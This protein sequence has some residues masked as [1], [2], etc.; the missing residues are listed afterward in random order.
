MS[1]KEAINVESAWDKVVTKYR[2]V[3]VLRREARVTESERVLKDELP[4]VIA[5]WAAANP[6]PITAKKAELEAM[7]AVE[8]K[9][10]DEALTLRRI[11]TAQ[12]NEQMLPLLHARVAEEVKNHF[13][14]QARGLPLTV[15]TDTKGGARAIVSMTPESFTVPITADPISLPLPTAMAQ[16]RKPNFNLA[17]A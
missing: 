6:R 5:A 2:E 14:E 1:A 4:G 16:R 7:F 13:A 11:L 10:V 9:R 17:R 15:A 12:M 3:C 8:R